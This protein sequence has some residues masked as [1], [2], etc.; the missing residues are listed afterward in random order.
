MRGNTSEKP[1]VDTAEE[2]FLSLVAKLLAMYAC[3]QRVLGSPR[4]TIGTSASPTKA[5]DAS[6]VS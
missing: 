5:S 4:A 3:E 6:R 2:R 1:A